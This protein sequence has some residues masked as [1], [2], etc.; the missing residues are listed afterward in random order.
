MRK[1]TLYKSLQNLIN[2]ITTEAKCSMA[3]HG[4]ALPFLYLLCR[5]EAE[6]QKADKT[7][8]VTKRLPAFV[9]VRGH[10]CTPGI[11]KHMRRCGF[12]CKKAVIKQ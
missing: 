4:K 6:E 11:F 2:T 9:R 7:P 5:H 10:L 8:M 3:E 1:G 12:C